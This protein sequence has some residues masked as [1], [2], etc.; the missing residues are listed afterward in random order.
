M[1]KLTNLDK[2]LKY[3][4]RYVIERYKKDYPDNQMPGKQ[5][6]Q[7]LLKYL[8]LT[9]KHAIDLAAAPKKKSLQF[10]VAMHYEMDEIDDMWHT[11][12]LFT[13]DYA[14]FCDKYFGHFIHHSPNTEKNPP[15]K[16]AFKADFERYLSYIYDEL[17]EETL[18]TWFG[19]LLK[20]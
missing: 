20:D 13:K 11:F 9:Q 12:I 14:A 18:I 8:W 7:E 4:N 16:T 19:A 17:G 10:V 5:A 1:N 6:W 2:V 3:K 15:S